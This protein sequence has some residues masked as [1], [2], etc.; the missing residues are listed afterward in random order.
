[1][2]GVVVAVRDSEPDHAAYRGLPSVWYALTQARRVAAGWAALAGNHVMILTGS[3]SVVALC[4]LQHHSVRVSV[5]QRVRTGEALGACGNTGNS[6]EPHLHLQALSTVD[7][8]HATAVPFTLGGR[9]PR[10]GEV[11][12]VP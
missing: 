7:V 3:G 10:N 4:H 9:L 8:P 12:E 1:M 6:T 2:E 5:G 11:V